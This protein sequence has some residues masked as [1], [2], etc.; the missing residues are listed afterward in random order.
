MKRP[1]RARTS[2]QTR[3]VAIHEAAHAVV[4]EVLGVGVWQ[5]SLDH[6]CLTR[7]VPVPASRQWYARNAVVACAGDIAERRVTPDLVLTDGHDGENAR[8]LLALCYA[9]TEVKERVQWA[10][11]QARRLVFDH[12]LAIERVAARLL[13]AGTL[14]GK[15]VRACIDG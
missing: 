12:W 6:G 14:D 4:A 15:G 10:K 13:R 2:K 8:R 9:K 7:F 11:K 3:H 5:V 1:Y